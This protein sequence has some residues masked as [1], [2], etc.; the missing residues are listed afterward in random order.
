MCIAFVPRS[1]AGSAVSI[2]P[3]SAPSFAPSFAPSIAPSIAL[4]FALSI[5]LSVAR[6]PTHCPTPWLCSCSSAPSPASAAERIASPKRLSE[7]RGEG[8]GGG[9]GPEMG[10]ASC[11]PMAALRKGRGV[12]PHCPGESGLNPILGCSLATPPDVPIPV[13]LPHRELL[14]LS[15]WAG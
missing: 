13:L 5:T 3:S 6:I 15:V 12:S 8:S 9:G 14:S 1:T 10:C 4:S 2:A 7:V 11:S